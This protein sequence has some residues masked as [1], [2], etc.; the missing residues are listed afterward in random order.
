[1]IIRRLRINNFSSFEGLNEFDLSPQKDKNIILIGGKNG[2]G[3]TSLF[4]AVK[5]ALYGPLAFGYTS[6]NSY[7]T[8][9]IKEFINSNA[10]QSSSVVSSVS[11]DFDVNTDRE[12]LSCFIERKWTY[13]NRR[14][15]EECEVI[16][17]GVLLDETEKRFFNNFLMSTIPPSLFNFFMFDGE[18]VGSVFSTNEYHAYAKDA[19]YT[20][21]GLDVYE[22]VR[23]ITA[24]YVARNEA[25]ENEEEQLEYEQ[26]LS[27]KEIIEKE[28]TEEECKLEECVQ[29]KEKLGADLTDLE[30]AFKNS[31]GI[32]DKERKKLE[33]EY[34]DNEKKRQEAS[35]KVKT[36]VEGLMPFFIVKD[37]A[38]MIINQLEQEEM[39]SVLSY[40]REKISKIDFSGL[41]EESPNKLVN[42][43]EKI[44]N[45]V[46]Q[47]FSPDGK[48]ETDLPIHDLSKED[49]RRIEAVYSL[50]DSF[51]SDEMLG[52]VET[53]QELT[54]RNSD[55]N[56]ALK[57]SMSE[58]DRTAFFGR[59]N[60]LLKQIAEA[61]SAV[62]ESTGR[63]EQLKN[64]LTQ[65]GEEVSRKKQK[66]MEDTQH[67][68]VYE[69]SDSISLIMT[70]LLSKKAE[71]LREKI[72]TQI[73][74]N[75]S[76]MYRKNNLITHVEVT[77]SFQFDLFQYSEYTVEQL[78]A[79]V[80]N[81]G[82]DEFISLIGKK[83][84]Q[85]MYREFDVSSVPEL[86]FRLRFSDK[87][88]VIK[89]YKKIDL[90][91][92]SKGERQMF[93]LAFY[94]AIIQIS[95]QD[96]PFVIDTPYARIDANHRKV[97]S[98]KFF[99]GI[100]N[101]VIILSTDEE[102]NEE[103]YGILSAHIAKEYLLSND[104]AENKTT[105]SKG[106]FFRATK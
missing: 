105:I 77:D 65:I 62:L 18:E 32:T 45:T 71:D 94:W 96:I 7:Y 103:Y 11:L 88:Q 102:V 47:A 9:R 3:K 46:L 2:A 26:L 55:I 67:R 79:L 4:S 78:L 37:N 27:R 29:R 8:A 41:V 57:N 54:I 69:L 35:I 12:V 13:V 91:R 63:V 22:L 30:D 92:L 42:L 95:G 6:A 100:S 31:G 51:S 99:P 106:Y 89:S 80:A 23:K 87:S 61:D 76:N 14:L 50:V 36:F 25:D 48:C 49:K 53:K 74:D 10:F 58:E 84:Q 104:E 60:S 101:Q 44:K 81:L 66:L 33:E 82:E 59:E 40:V 93:I 64:E 75:R 20:M 52:V 24:N 1:M 97:I 86:C 70:Q 28:I 16:R 83:G 38:L 15:V 19:L 17:N 21:C 56:R 73:V 34:S 43:T 68:H 5:I 85:E 39:L 90:S 98:E 72:E